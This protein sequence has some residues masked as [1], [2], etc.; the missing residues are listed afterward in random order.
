[1]LNIGNFLQKSSDLFN[2]T[3]YN[4]IKY[5]YTRLY[6]AYLNLPICQTNFKWIS[7]TQGVILV[8]DITNRWSF[9]G[10]DRWIKE[11]DEVRYRIMNINIYLNGKEF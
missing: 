1:M 2:T 8:Y 9:D 3:S 5:H 7:F 10:I 4:V 6:D 11:I